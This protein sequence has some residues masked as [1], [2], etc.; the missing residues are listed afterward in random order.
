M[1][2]VW[3]TLKIAAVLAAGAWLTA[4]GLPRLFVRAGRA[5]GFAMKLTPT[6]ARRVARFKR[7]KR[8]YWAFIA[9]CTAIL[10]SLFLELLVNH[11]PLVMAYDGRVVFPAVKD[12]AAGA[13]FFLKISSFYPREQF[14]QVGRSEV[15]YREFARQ[16]EDPS[17]G[18]AA[19]AALR[20]EVMS[21]IAEYEREN[22]RPGPGST[23]GARSRW[24]RGFAKFS[25]RQEDVGR[26][27]AAQKI[28]ESGRAWI[29]P[30][31][32]PYGPNETRLDFEKPPPN[33]PSL[34]LGVPL[35]TDTSGRDILV[36]L[37]YGFRISI[38]F[39][40]IV[41][42]VGT[43]LGVVIGATQGYFMGWVDIVTQRV[44][45]IWSSI[46]FLYVIMIIA[47]AVPPTFL[48]LVA[49]MLVLRS[50]LNITYYVRGEFLREKA[51]DYVQAAIGMGVSEWKIMVRHILPNAMVPI[52]TFTP[53]AIVG[54]IVSL[55][56]L[57]YL[58]FGL[59]PGTPSW[60]ALMK[61]GL[62]NVK[63]HPHLIIIP[64]TALA[65]TLY[66]IVLVGEAVREAFD[67]KVFSRLR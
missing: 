16:A 21:G 49:L 19:I 58:G 39:A 15:D 31:L 27:E 59:P 25:K 29:V 54:Y 17:V 7:I 8:G 57:D 10:L 60:G 5:L 13:L 48:L 32:F 62:E 38:F 46:P 45:E 30:T 52:V 55:V 26:L 44:E 22:P 65:V 36:Q 64:V 4:R 67:P 12:W 33:S 14:G 53:F 11:K 47:A 51:K 1:G 61:Q 66:L 41:T 50:W 37:L 9:V 34:R 42:A 35:G 40:L 23:T 24:E 18:L 43:A 63:F 6:T 3:V 2:A 56:S 20:A 28:R